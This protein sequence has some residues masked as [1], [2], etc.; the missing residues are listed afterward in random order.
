MTWTPAQARAAAL[1]RW[2]RVP[3]PLA[4]TAPGRAAFLARFD[5]EV[6][7]DR[8]LDPAERHV[9]ATRAMRAHMI[10]LAEKSAAKRARR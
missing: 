9:R 5:N 3:D 4:A 8:T 2:A 7:P 6:D 10:R 1:D